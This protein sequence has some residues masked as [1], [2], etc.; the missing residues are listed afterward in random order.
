MPEYIVKTHDD[1]RS[2][3]I[4]ADRFIINKDN[5]SYDF[6]TKDSLVASVNSRSILGVL[7][8][9][10]AYQADFHEDDDPDDTR[11]DFRFENFLE[12]E[13]FYN[14]VAEVVFDVLDWLENEDKPGET[15][16]KP[17][18]KVEQRV[19]DGIVEWGLVTPNGWV[20][21]GPEA[22]QEFA[23]GVAETWKPEHFYIY[24]P[25]EQTEVIQ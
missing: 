1:D 20:G 16:E 10:E 3:V 11:L 8:F 12:S 15:E 5:G 22:T 18:I 2:L 7:E 21:F 14:T 4:K 6:F 17:K 9:E 13:D 25:L 24:L 19:V 23:E